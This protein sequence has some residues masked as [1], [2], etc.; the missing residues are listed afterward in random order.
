MLD[1][2]GS[3]LDVGLL[4]FLPG[5]ASTF[6]TLGWGRVGDRIGTTW[7]MVSTG[8]FFTAVFSVPV[9][10]STKPW[11][12]IL[13]TS[14]QALLGSIS[15]VTITV[16]FAELLEPSKRARFMGIYN[17]LGYAGNITGSFL[18]GLFIPII[19]YKYTFLVYTIL[20]LVIAGIIRYWL[21]TP[22]EAMINLV[23]LIRMAFTELWKGLKDLPN[24]FNN[25]GPYTRWSIGIS[26]RGFG[27]AMFGP[28]LTLYLVNVFQASKPE[29]GALT[30]TAFLVRLL[31]APFL[32]FVVDK[33]GPKKMMI[34]GLLFAMAHPIIFSTIPEVSYLLI[35]YVVSGLYWAFINSSWFTWQMNL[36]PSN[37]GV[38]A[39]FF[40]FIN[41]LAWA[42]GPLFGGFLGDIIGLRYCAF[43]SSSIVLLSLFIMLQVPE[44]IDLESV[45]EN[46]RIVQNTNDVSKL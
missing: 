29:I 3:S 35:V 24:T 5:L 7:K 9:L 16:R 20:N 39:G 31:G 11:Q 33:H 36:I 2:G 21:V 19:G 32:G 30:S 23:D 28:V 41:G 42:F 12:I 8:F 17:P 22:S 6:M 44:T 46:Q 18:A 4:A 15:E 37:R 14:L 27:I 10:F 1:L 26:V 38:Y 43:L 13:A 25:G 45:I 34:I 40:S